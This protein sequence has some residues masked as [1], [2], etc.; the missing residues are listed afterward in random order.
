MLLIFPTHKME[1]LPSGRDP[2]ELELLPSGRD[3]TE[4]ELLP[5]GRDPILCGVIESVPLEAMNRSPLNIL[6]ILPPHFR[7]S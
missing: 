6:A 5:S 2:T 1:L 4:L 7:C 3:P